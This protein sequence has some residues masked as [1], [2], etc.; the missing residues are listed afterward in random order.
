MWKTYSSSSI[1]SKNSCLF[2]LAWMIFIYGVNNGKVGSK[3]VE[4]SG[5]LWLKFRWFAAGLTANN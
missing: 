5:D 1:W 2:P 4:I 3:L